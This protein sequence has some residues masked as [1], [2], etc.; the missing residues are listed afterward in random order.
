MHKKITIKD[1][2]R[3]CGVSITTVSRVLNN[4]REGV[5]E[6]T[7][8]RIR[9]VIGELKYQ[10]NVVARSMITKRSNTIGLILPDIRNPFFSELA[11]G[12]ED[13][14]NRLGYGCFLCNTDGEIEKEDKYIQLLRGRVADGILFTT[15][16]NVESNEAFLEFQSS[17]FPFC[18]IERYIDEMP[19]VPG[20]YFDNFNGAKLITEYL[21]DRGHRRIAFISGPLTTHNARQRRDGY[22]EALESR[23]IH[24]DELL[25]VEGN[26]RYDGGYQAVSLLTGERKM[27]YT[28]IFASNDLM[29]LGALQN[30][31]ER[32][33]R[34][35]D[36]ISLAGFDHIAFP[37]VL[38]PTIT[39]VEIPAY[40]FGVS[41]ATLLFSL[42]KGERPE[43]TKIVFTPKLVEK[44]SV[45]SL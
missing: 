15:Q 6:E 26:Y 43:Q 31:E 38:R 36:D 10:P 5:G 44:G 9:Q 42:M 23:G 32:G 28:A 12:V 21:I 19:D 18:F 35:P 2:A 14:C 7:V 37:P 17:G 22:L 29:A 25:F 40:E 1:I 13:V 11:R 16:N 3:L 33:Y 45:R 24:A 8:E 39:T 4:K 41:S 20:V 34:I 27:D 30:L